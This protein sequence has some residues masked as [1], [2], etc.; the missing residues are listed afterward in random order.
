[1]KKGK[2]VAFYA[3]NDKSAN[4]FDEIDFGYTVE[5]KG[6]KF[7]FLIPKSMSGD[8]LVDV[9]ENQIK[10]YTDILGDWDVKAK[11]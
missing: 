9:L 8:E 6:N 2:Y 1:M 5:R 7:Y 11:F 3:Q 4:L 10:H